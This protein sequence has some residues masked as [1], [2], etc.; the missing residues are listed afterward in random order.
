MGFRK[1]FIFPIQ[2]MKR[3]FLTVS[4]LVFKMLTQTKKSNQNKEGLIIK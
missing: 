4:G 2:Q 1:Q 3:L